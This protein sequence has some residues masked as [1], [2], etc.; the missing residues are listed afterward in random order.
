[1]VTED[2]LARVHLA[3]LEAMHREGWAIDGAVPV[4][5]LSI[6]IE[7]GGRAVHAV[8]SVPEADRARVLADLAKAYNGK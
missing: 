4:L 8:G 6:F 1:M 2:G 7:P 3:T 5:S